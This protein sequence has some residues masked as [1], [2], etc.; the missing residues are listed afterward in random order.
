M[1]VRSTWRREAPA[2][3]SSPNSRERWAT[4]IDSELK[5]V[6]APTSSATPPKASRTP[7]MIEMNCFRPVEGEAIVLRRR[8]DPCVRQRRREVVAHLRRRHAVAARRRG[9]SPRARPCRTGPAAVFRV[10]NRDRR[11]AEGLDRAERGQAGDA[12]AARR[13]GRRDAHAVADVQ[14]LP[15]SAVPASSTTWPGPLAH[16]PSF[17]RNGVSLPPLA[18]AAG[19]SLTPNQG[20]SPATLPSSPTIRA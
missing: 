8:L 9:S 3:R 4:A 13:A 5:I 19:S 16:A 2:S 11:G 18:A 7:L 6:N 1:T 10:E 12:E 17:S 15:V 14:V 20:P